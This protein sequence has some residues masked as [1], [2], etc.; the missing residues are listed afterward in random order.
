MDNKP[1]PAKKV[2]TEALNNAMP[3]DAGVQQPV[4]TPEDSVK[5]RAQYRITDLPVPIQADQRWAKKFLP[6]VIL[7]AGSQEDCW[8]FPDATLLRHIQVIFN[9]TYPELDLM[10]V[11][12]GVV[13]SL[14]SPFSSSTCIKKFTSINRLFNGFQNGEATSAQQQSHLLLTSWWQTKN[15]TCRS[16][17]NFF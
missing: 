1:P 2:K 9:A 8:N 4:D 15:A 3:T 10:V 14:V 16:L 17:Q 7:W 6:T 12:N 5:P 11:Q 13:F